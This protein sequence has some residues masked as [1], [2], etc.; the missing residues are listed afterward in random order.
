M[1]HSLLAHS[2]A[3]CLLAQHSGT[4]RALQHNPCAHLVLHLL[5][6]H[7]CTEAPK[8]Q[9]LLQGSCAGLSGSSTARWPCNNL[10]PGTSALPV[11]KIVNLLFSHA[12]LATSYLLLLS[13]QAPLVHA[14]GIW[15]PND[16]PGIHLGI[17]GLLIGWQPRVDCDQVWVT[18]QGHKALWRGEPSRPPGK[19]R[20]LV[21]QPCHT[22]VGLLFAQH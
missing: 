14:G 10:E 20:Q 16:E 5:T 7:A 22:S 6:S 8:P 11:H 13:L 17:Q 15:H 19:H 4:C 21:Q 2:A 12:W 18:L 9:H 3:L 1:Q